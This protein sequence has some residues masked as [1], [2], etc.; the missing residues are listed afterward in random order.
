MLTTIVVVVALDTDCVIYQD[1]CGS[2]QEMMSTTRVLV[3]AIRTL[4]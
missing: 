4:C 1:G 3:V 2:N